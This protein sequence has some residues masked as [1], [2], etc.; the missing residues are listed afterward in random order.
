MRVSVQCCAYTQLYCTTF[1]LNIRAA[2]LESACVFG[3]VGIMAH[4]ITNGGVAQMVAHCF[5]TAGVNGSS[6]F[7]SIIS[8]P[9]NKTGPMTQ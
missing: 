7:I 4:K 3:H 8:F 9:I 5:C 1:V 2:L 6:P